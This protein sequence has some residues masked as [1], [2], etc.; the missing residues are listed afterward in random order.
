MLFLQSPVHAATKG[1]PHRLNVAVMRPLL[2]A[3]YAGL[4]SI[5][6]IREQHPNVLCCAALQVH[7]V[8]TRIF[9]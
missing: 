8:Q 9:S 1:Q 6:P 7:A 4:N 2:G 5:P 3:G